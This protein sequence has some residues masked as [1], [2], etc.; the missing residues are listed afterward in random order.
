MSSFSREKAE[1]KGKRPSIGKKNNTNHRCIHR[2]ARSVDGNAEM[3]SIDWTQGRRVP[4]I[5]LIARSEVCVPNAAAVST[6]PLVRDNLATREDDTSR[7]WKK[8][9]PRSLANRSRLACLARKEWNENYVRSSLLFIKCVSD[10]YIRNVIFNGLEFDRRIW[11][12][13]YTYS[14]QRQRL[15]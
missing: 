13:V 9:V 8:K 7:L 4:T 1:S 3:L 15:R 11:L 5:N 12:R 14:V 6:V 10:T 2:L